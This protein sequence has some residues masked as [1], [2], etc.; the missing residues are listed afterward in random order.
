MS[1]YFSTTK[2]NDHITLIKSITGEDLYYVQG[3]KEGILIDTSEGMSPLKPLVDQLA[4][5]PYSVILT[6]G[7]IDHAMGASEFRDHKVFMNLSDRVVYDGMSD[8]EQRED[9][10]K[11]CIPKF[12]KWSDLPIKP[13]PS[14]HA[15]DNF[16]DLKDGQVFDLGGF[17]LETIH[18][19]GHT[20]G[21]TAIL[22]I[23]DRILLTGDGANRS[24]FVWDEYAPS[25]HSYRAN[26]EYLLKRTKGKYDYIYISHG[27][28]EVSPRLLEN[29]IE[30]CDEIIA[31]KTDD[32][33]NEFMGKTYYIAKKFDPNSPTLARDDGKDGNIF[34]NPK[35]I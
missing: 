27:S 17:H 21:M 19:P 20:P 34:Y 1:K 3:N 9:Y 5:T 6:H 11:Q 30:L 8:E 18:F 15:D 12:I 31:R 29:L 33:P 28:H 23:E 16:L 22:F 10:A 4:K 35:N 7:H 24:T 25:V 26:L 14:E 32:I 13:A 2:I